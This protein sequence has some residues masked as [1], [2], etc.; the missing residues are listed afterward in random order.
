MDTMDVDNLDIV[1]AVADAVASAVKL[2]PPPPALPTGWIMRDSRSNPG[3]FYYYN[4]DT[5]MTD[6]SP[7]AALQ[8]QQAPPPPPLSAAHENDAGDGLPPGLDNSSNS[9]EKDEDPET[10]EDRASKRR[11]G[12]EEIATS[13]NSGSSSSSSPKEVR[14]LHLLKK[15]KGSR[16]PSSWRQAKITHSVEEARDE[17]VGMLEILKDEEG[18]PAEL[19]A[20]F[21]E[22]A[23][24]ESDCSSA[25]RGGDLGFF[26]RRRMQP[27]FEAASFGLK[28]GELT[29]E[30]VETSSG[31]HLILR[32]G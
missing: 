4:M 29:K 3:Y 25:K 11:K 13:S 9:N 31:V 2:G 21:E 15:H 26:G 14:V 16:R 8:Q 10:A 19:R 24:T 17:L 6:W 27:A 20:T 23:R 28:L 5:G 30:I 18:N 22:L 12:G 7:P 1:T 32:I